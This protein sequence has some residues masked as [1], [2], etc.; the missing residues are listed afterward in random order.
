MNQ[1]SISIVQH[2][3]IWEDKAANLESL[4]SK[5]NAIKK[6]ELVVLP[7]MFSTGFTMDPAPNAETMEGPTVHWM[8]KLAQTKKIALAGSIIIEENGNYYNRLILAL[9]NG[10]TGTYDKRHLFAF[11]GENEQYT[12]G[13]KR[14]I[15]SIN[16]IKINLQICYDIR[17]P[18]W[19]R[20][21]QRENEPEYDVLINIANWPQKRSYHWKTLLTARAIENQCYV[22]GVNRTG[23]DGNGHHYNGQSRIINPLGNTVY[24]ANIMEDVFTYTI[25]K[26]EIDSIRNDFPFLKDADDF[27]IIK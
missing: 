14:F 9:P 7:E 3:I 24:A 12:A 6:T 4:E 17:F 20:Q 19:A 23:V 2:N 21:H 22:V 10:K 27:S 26:A 11:A 13:E 16:G 8:L 18:V 5:I 1:L 25:T 15:T